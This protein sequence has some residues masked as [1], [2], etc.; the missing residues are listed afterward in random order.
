M[1]TL[2]QSLDEDER[3]LIAPGCAGLLLEG[4]AWIHRRREAV[5][6]L[7]ENALKRQISVDFTLPQDSNCNPLQKVTGRGFA[8]PVY[9]LPKTE[10]ANLM[11]FDLRDESGGAMP[12]MTKRENKQISAEV[13][14]EMAKLVLGRAPETALANRLRVI[15]TGESPD[16]EPLAEDL[17]NDEAVG[18]P[19]SQIGKLMADERFCWWLFTLAHSSLVLVWVEEVGVRRIIKLSFRGPIS[20]D[21]SRLGRLGWSPYEFLVDSSYI[22]ART[23]HFEAQAPNGLR[24][25]EGHMGTDRSDPQVD[26]DGFKRRIHPYASNAE[27]DGGA[28]VKLRLRVS[29]DGFIRN[30]WL[31]ALL[32]TGAFLGAAQ[33]HVQIAQNPTSAPTMLLLLPGL[34]ATY[35]SRPDHHALT[36]RLL[37][38]ARYALLCA[39]LIAYL[40]AGYLA[41]L[42]PVVD[43]LKPSA[44]ISADILA[45][46]ED[47]VQVV[48]ASAA[49]LSVI[50]LLLLFVAFVRATRFGPLLSPKPLRP[51]GR[52]IG[53][54]AGRA[55]YCCRGLLGTIHC[56]RF[57]IDEVTKASVDDARQILLAHTSL[58]ELESRKFSY[59][60][61]TRVIM[62]DLKAELRRTPTGSRLSC[63]GQA[64]GRRGMPKTVVG[65]RLG[66]IYFRLR[67]SI[68]KRLPAPGSRVVVGS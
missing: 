47:Q 39:A 49:A 53:E 48:L 52:W 54:R 6:I 64:F 55:R 65:M 25:V 44:A 30:A 58:E 16:A 3:D 17:L 8:V 62:P 41:T 45:S 57:A 34:V 4:A 43:R 37:T 28:T 21:P 66:W 15:G 35:V 40:G 26:H 12:L 38:F 24:L 7:D 11:S 13:L 20:N 46:R 1:G 29:A 68:A 51:P 9:V 50:P 22:E 36:S 19:E 14:V 56:R 18:D 23:H 2:D 42:G 60:P 32:I 10:P 67:W 63:D 31:P 59:R 27:R 5:E 33:R 61:V